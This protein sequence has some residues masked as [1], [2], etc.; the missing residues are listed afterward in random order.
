[1]RLSTTVPASRQRLTRLLQTDQTFCAHAKG[2]I[3]IPVPRTFPKGDRFPSNL[4]HLHR[5]DRHLLG[6]PR[7][8]RRRRLADRPAR[9]RPRVR[10]PRLR[11]RV[12]GARREA[13]PAAEGAERR[14]QLPGACRAGR[15][16]GGRGRGLRSERL[17]L[18]PVPV[19]RGSALRTPCTRPGFCRGEL[20]TLT[21]GTPAHGPHHTDLGR[22]PSPW[23]PRCLL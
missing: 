22:L 3:R 14:L 23:T 17:Q 5:R 13:V 20:R 9:A 21:P 18:L 16:S 2:S 4:E 11:T 15:V 1:M 7:V 10:V 12:P 8:K 19:G 6:R